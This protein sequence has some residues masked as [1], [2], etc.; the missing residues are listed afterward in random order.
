LI[1]AVVVGE[2]ILAGAA[3]RLVRARRGALRLLLA[4]AIV[5][6]VAVGGGVLA[7]L[8]VTRTRRAVEL[9]QSENRA[10][11]AR[12]QLL[13]EQIAA[14]EVRLVETVERGLPLAF[15]DYPAK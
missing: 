1:S 14:L 9:A 2:R 5:T 8:D 15:E 7:D 10:L 4:L 12:Q 11:R 6:G 13:R 3:G